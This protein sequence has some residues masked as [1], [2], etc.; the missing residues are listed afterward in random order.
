MFNWVIE[1]ILGTCAF[2]DETPPGV[3]IVDVRDLPDGKADPMQIIRK[4]RTIIKC[5]STGNAIVIRC[6][7]GISRSNSIVVG[8]LCTMNGKSWDENEAFVKK[9]VPQFQVNL[10]FKE[11]CLEALGER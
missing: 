8:V 5:L 7:A 9:A 1:D 11:S 3:I 10:A 6:Q 2:G 4:I